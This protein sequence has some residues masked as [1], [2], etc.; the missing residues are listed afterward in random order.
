MN[1]SLIND[2]KNQTPNVKKNINRTH[3]ALLDELDSLE[4]T[5]VF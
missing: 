3:S 2:F 5:C 1:R 4:Y